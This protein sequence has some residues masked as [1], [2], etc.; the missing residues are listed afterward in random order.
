[1]CW[2]NAARRREAHRGS[3]DASL[4]HHR[5]YVGIVSSNSVTIYDQ[6]RLFGYHSRNVRKTTKLGGVGQNIQFNIVG[7]L[8]HL[9]A[10]MRQ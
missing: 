5:A 1:M 2:G 9:I 7:Q 6:S 8:M 3:T 4:R 10:L